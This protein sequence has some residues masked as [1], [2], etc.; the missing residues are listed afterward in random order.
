MAKMLRVKAGDNGP[1]FLP[2][3]IQGQT[4]IGDEPIEVESTRFIRRRIEAGDL[5]VVEDEFVDED[6]VNTAALPVPRATFTAEGGVVQG[7]QVLPDV[8]TSAVPAQPTTTRRRVTN[9]PTDKE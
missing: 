3:P 9:P 5:V 1:V 2:A 6:E 4:Q 8:Q 7:A